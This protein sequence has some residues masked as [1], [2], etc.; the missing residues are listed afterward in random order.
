MDVYARRRLVAVLAIVL[1]LVLIGVAVA[2]GGDDEQTPITTVTTGTTD[3]ALATPLSKDEFIEEGDAICAE[4]AVAVASLTSDDSQ[5]LA[6]DELEYTESQLD[7][8]R[9]L[10]PP[11]EDQKTLDEFFAAMEDQVDALDKRVLALERADDSAALEAETELATATDELLGAAKDYG[12]SE[13]GRAGEASTDTDTDT[14][15]PTD[16]G[17]VPAAPATTP[18]A[19]ATTPTTPVAPTDSSSS[20]SGGADPDSG[21]VAP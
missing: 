2:G 18:T 12:F 15:V 13:C 8:L 3:P 17:A 14:E 19:P 7:Q 16:T 6:D 9:S 4:T 1:V 5:T 21:G 20:S 11:E 10:V